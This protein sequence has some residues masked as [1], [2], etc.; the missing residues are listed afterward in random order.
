MTYIHPRSSGRFSRRS[1]RGQD[2][3][4]RAMGRSV[5]D[6]RDD[7]NACRNP[8]PLDRQKRRPRQLSMERAHRG[9]DRFAHALQVVE[10]EGRCCSRLVPEPE[11]SRVG[12]LRF[13]RGRC[14]ALA[15]RRPCKQMHGLVLVGFHGISSTERRSIRTSPDAQLHDAAAP[16]AR[17]LL[18]SRLEFSHVG[19][20]TSCPARSAT[21]YRTPLICGTGH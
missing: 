16:E 4:D 20:Q 11:C 5:Y 15:R 1:R 19:R 9:I 17:E 13:E 6:G 10:G 2:P 14:R 8:R 12:A 7:G 18:G 21:G 3:T